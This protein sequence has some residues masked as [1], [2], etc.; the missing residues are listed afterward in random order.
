MLG[1]LISPR[2]FRTTLNT[3]EAPGFT[4]RLVTPDWVNVVMK[5]RHSS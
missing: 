5:A 1:A 3:I 4:S 2:F